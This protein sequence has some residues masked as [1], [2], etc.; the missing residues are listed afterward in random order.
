[1]SRSL[2]TSY[3]L[4]YVAFAIYCVTDRLWIYVA[5]FALEDL[6][7]LRL[8]GLSQILL[9][10]APALLSPSV[11]RL[12]D[13][14]DRLHGAHFSILTNNLSMILSASTLLLSRTFLLSGAPFYVLVTVSLTFA[15]LGKVA[16][17]GELIVMSRDW[18]VVLASSEAKKESPLAVRNAAMTTIYQS[19]SVVAPVLGG[20]VVSYLGITSTCV[21]FA[22][23][24]S[25]SLVAKAVLLKV[26]YV[27]VPSLAE[28][29]VYKVS[30]IEDQAE[31]PNF[32]R[33]PMQEYLSQPVLP[34]AFGIAALYITAFQFDGLV[35]GYAESQGITADI[36]GT[37]GSVWAVFGLLGSFAYTAL[38]R[39]IGLNHTGLVGVTSY[40][41]AASPCI[42]SLFLPGGLFSSS[43]TD[44]HL[45]MYSYLAGVCLARFG[46]WITH[47][48]ILQLIQETVPESNRNA[49]FGV[50][51]A[52]CYSFV[53]VKNLIITVVPGNS[54]FALLI[55]ASVVV[56]VVVE[57]CFIYYVRKDR[58]KAV[59][60]SA[61]S[62]GM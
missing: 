8:V 58:V 31:K 11:G 30:V 15:S 19:C 41:I 43:S 50:Q 44:S 1:M 7:G 39:Y 56:L 38:E 22:V 26:V 12:L 16:S 4:F 62:S 27:N 24:S 42:V 55:V 32:D 52:A 5:A 37:F 9:S 6:G 18:V 2:F 25:M 17:D 46:F 47:L 14:H 45:A 10:A 36:V 29:D 57:L 40:C 53:L 20:F 49:V 13:S 35:I 33:S 3:I 51:N 61:D 23:W 48:A 21:V 59:D 60:S 54:T 28:R 34:A